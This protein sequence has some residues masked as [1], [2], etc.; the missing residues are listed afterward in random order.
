MKP[1]QHLKIPANSQDP[2]WR[3]HLSVTRT[4]KKTELH[5]SGNT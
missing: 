3:D 2:M 5:V 4:L 1:V